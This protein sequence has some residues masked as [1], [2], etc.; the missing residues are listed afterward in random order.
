MPDLTPDEA[1]FA[2]LPRWAREE[3][4][5]LRDRRFEI[6]VRAKDGRLEFRGATQPIVT[7]GEPD[8]WVR[9]RLENKG[10]K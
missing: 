4:K 8:G 6:S 1:R 10:D 7:T 5:R 2:R 3:I 9:I